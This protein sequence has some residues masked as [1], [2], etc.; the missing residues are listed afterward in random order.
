MDDDSRDDW[1][2]FFARERNFSSKEMPNTN[3]SD[4]SGWRMK[5]SKGEHSEIDDIIISL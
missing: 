1:G 5:P 4:L 2:I 3:A